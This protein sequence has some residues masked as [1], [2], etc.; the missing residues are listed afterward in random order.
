M[1]LDPLRVRQRGVASFR[2]QAQHR[3]RTFHLASARTDLGPTAMTRD[4][5][6]CSPR[7]SRRNPADRAQ[8]I[9]PKPAKGDASLAYCDPRFWDTQ[10]VRPEPWLASESPSCSGTSPD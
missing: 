3:A 1:K 9:G 7:R 4:S 5:A 6:L 10:Q 8:N 2:A